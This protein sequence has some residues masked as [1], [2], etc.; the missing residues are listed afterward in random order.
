MIYVLVNQHNWREKRVDSHGQ[1]YTSIGYRPPDT[2]EQAKTWPGTTIIEADEPP[3]RW[4]HVTY[5]SI[6][7]ELELVAS[8]CDSSG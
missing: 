4:G 1:E 7:G 5:Q 2:L 6:S 3:I 8:D